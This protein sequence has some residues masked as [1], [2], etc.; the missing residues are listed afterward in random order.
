MMKY[1][2]TATRRIISFEKYV[3]YPLQ[4]IYQFAVENDDEEQ[5]NNKVKEVLGIS[6]DVIVIDSVTHPSIGRLLVEASLRGKLILLGMNVKDYFGGMI[7]LEEL[8]VSKALFLDELTFFVRQQSVRLI[9]S[10]CREVDDS[11][12]GSS[13]A[14]FMGG[15]V[16]YKG[17][18]CEECSNTGYKGRRGLFEGLKVNDRI[19]RVLQGG[20]QQRSLRK[21]YVKE[22]SSFLEEEAIRM[23]REKLTTIEDVQRVGLVEK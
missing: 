3:E 4:N 23:V 16:F 7:K 2:N 18:G 15:G 12:M 20:F 14:E 8:G 1:M 9:C 5:I 10:Q 11:C 19:R 17:T 13:L 6:P 21:L 22:G